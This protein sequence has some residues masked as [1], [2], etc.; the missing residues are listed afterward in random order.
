MLCI[1]QVRE[2]MAQQWHEDIDRSKMAKRVYASV[3]KVDNHLTLLK[4]VTFKQK[5]SANFFGQSFKLL[6]HFTNS[7]KNLSSSRNYEIRNQQHTDVVYRRI[8][9]LMNC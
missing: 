4:K 8:Y 7:C 5:S 1:Q 9:E 6:V 2:K 3:T